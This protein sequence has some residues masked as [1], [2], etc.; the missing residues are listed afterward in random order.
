MWSNFR[1]SI[2]SGGRPDPISS[3]S[4]CACVVVL[5][6]FQIN[7]SCE[8]VCWIHNM[9]NSLMHTHFEIWFKAHFLHGFVLLSCTAVLYYSTNT[10]HRWKSVYGLKFMIEENLSYE[11]SSYLAGWVAVKILNVCIHT[12]DKFMDLVKRLPIDKLHGSHCM[13]KRVCKLYASPEDIVEQF[14]I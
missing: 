14:I 7:S 1:I 6:R 8:Q 4:Y 12:F 5:N 2:R 11:L 9:N 10:F 13:Y 3:V